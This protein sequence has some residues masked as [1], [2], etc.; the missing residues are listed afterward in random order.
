MVK[1]TELSYLLLSKNIDQKFQMVHGSWRVISIYFS[2]V[3][4]GSM[5]ASIFDGS[6]MLV[7]ASGGD[8]ALVFA[9]LA[10][11]IINWDS[12]IKNKPWKWL[13]LGFLSEK[14]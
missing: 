8:Y 4:A 12:M 2:G 10:N 1:L 6:K 5:L 14:L 9:F 13:R 3:I 11:L 7:G